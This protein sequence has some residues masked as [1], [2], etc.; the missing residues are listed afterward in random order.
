MITDNKNFTVEYYRPG[1][2]IDPDTVGF[3]DIGL[4]R[5]VDSMMGKT[6]SIFDGGFYTHSFSI[7]K[8]GGIIAEALEWGVEIEDIEKYADDYFYVI[9]KLDAT[10]EQRIA[11]FN[12]MQSV[13]L[14]KNPKRVNRYG[15]GIIASMAL[16]KIFRHNIVFGAGV[17]TNICSGFS[18]T[19]S[20]GAAYIYPEDPAY[21]SPNDIQR[22]FN[23]RTP[24]TEEIQE[25]K[26]LTGEKNGS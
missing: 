18:A 21:V 23:I 2:G 15:Y 26:I 12:F 10:P 11:M 17:G 13:V 8:P 14:A 16:S 1:E 3:G 4:T 25:H 19:T 5:R 22:K 9:I 6:I 24:T 20:R 7:Y